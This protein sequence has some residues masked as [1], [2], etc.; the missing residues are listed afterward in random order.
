MRQFACILTLFMFLG[1]ASCGEDSPV[2]EALDSPSDEVDILTDEEISDLPNY[3]VYVLMSAS[4]SGL[5]RFIALFND[6]II[7]KSREEQPIT[8]AYIK[9][10]DVEMIFG[11]GPRAETVFSL[12]SKG[13]FDFI[14]QQ[15]LLTEIGAD[16]SKIETVVIETT[17]FD[18]TGV[19]AT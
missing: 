11:P 12:I 13:S 16:A 17:C 3:E 18:H 5:D 10:P 1:I 7:E 8:F 4:W 6:D 19:K 9:G 15:T 2:D 14:D